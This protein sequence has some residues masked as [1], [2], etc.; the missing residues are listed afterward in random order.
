[1]NASK[2]PR[3]SRRGMEQANQIERRVKTNAST[4]QVLNCSIGG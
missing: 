1:M 4:E 2:D 3:H